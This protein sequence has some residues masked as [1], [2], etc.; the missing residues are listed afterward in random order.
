MTIQMDQS[1]REAI[2]N[3]LAHAIASA[4]TGDEV[5]SLAKAARILDHIGAL[6]S[7]RST[8]MKALEGKGILV[9]AVELLCYVEALQIADEVAQDP[10]QVS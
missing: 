8:A 10:R 5:L 6:T 3:Q 7:L 4:R 9:G 2:G 1:E